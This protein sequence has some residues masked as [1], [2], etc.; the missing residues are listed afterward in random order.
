LGDVVKQFASAISL[1]PDPAQAVGEV[2]GSIIDEIG[3]EPTVLAVFVTAPF[4]SAM[5]DISAALARI[6]KPTVMIGSTAVSVVGRDHEAEQVPALSVWAGRLPGEVWPVR[7]EAVRT[8]SGVVVG[9]LDDDVSA[10]ARSM[11]VV[12]DPFTFPVDSWLMSMAAQHPDIAV[13]GGL[14]SAGRAPGENRL[15][16]DG[17]A[18]GHGAIGFATS[19]PVRTVVSQGC[20]PIGDPFTVTKVHGNAVLEL[21]GRPG[22]ERAIATIEA[23]SDHDRQ[24][25]MQGLHIGIVTNANAVEYQRGDFLIRGVLGVD[26]ETGAVIVGDEVEVGDTVQFQV[27]DAASADDDL[28]SLLEA[29]DANAALVFTCNGRGQHL[30]G[31]LHHDATVIGNYTGATAIAGMFC[32]GELGPV[33][34]RNALHGFTASIALW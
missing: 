26:R 27:R 6:V 13:I 20:R 28:K 11:V 15:V 1:H 32:A 8:A 3:V 2:A 29:T 25:A 10:R 31:E 7:L 33:A 5:A 23:L 18:L 34:G 22:V 17:A 9:S 19:E 12:A 30:F 24:L 4:V 21:G 16:L 14:A